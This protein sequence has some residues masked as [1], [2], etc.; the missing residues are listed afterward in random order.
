[1][2]AAVMYEKKQTIQYLTMITVE[3]TINFSN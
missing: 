3:K 2:S 1:M